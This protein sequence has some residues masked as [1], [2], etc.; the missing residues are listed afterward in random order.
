MNK[1]GIISE[2]LRERIEAL[3]Y[4]YVGAE[5]VTENS[6]KI[7]RVYADKPDG[8]GTDDCRAIAN[9]VDS[10]LDMYEADMPRTYLFEV[11]SPGVERP[12]FSTED[13]R[14]FC[15]REAV[16]K[17]RGR[18]RFNGAIGE[19]L[20]DDVIVFYGKDGTERRLRLEEIGRAN[21]VFERQSGEKKT[22]KKIPKKKNKKR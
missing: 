20:D 5:F 13:Y 11:S 2:G 1:L 17:P 10:L 19:V 3:G 21:L 12:L 22:F 15:G 7:L 8:L 14:E 9:E 4:K 6:L 18:T 16:V